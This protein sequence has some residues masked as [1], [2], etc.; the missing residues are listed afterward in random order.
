M[1]LSTDDDLLALINNIKQLIKPIELVKCA[2]D[3]INRAI[4]STAIHVGE[5][6]LQEALLLPAAHE[7]F[8]DFVSDFAAMTNLEM[9]GNEK[10]ARWVLSNLIINP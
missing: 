7:I 5:K 1:P 10:S 8:S 2:E 6:L 9:V 4:Y 3:L